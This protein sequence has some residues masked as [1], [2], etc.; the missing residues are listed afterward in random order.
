MA[1]L[2]ARQANQARIV[3]LAL[4]LAVIAAIG[5]LLI[6][7]GALG[8]GDLQT[9][10]GPPV[11]IYISAGSYLLGGLLILL[12][13]RWLW[14]VGAVLNALVMLVFFNFYLDRPAVM[15]SPGGLATKIAQLL[16]EACLI[17]LIAT[18]GGRPR[19]RL[20]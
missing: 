16:L 14:V 2:D 1:I 15:F 12:R 19:N 11:I 5:Y 6:G 18:A 9:E 17:Y 10:E 7:S 13:W 3:W 20:A 8:V 4:G